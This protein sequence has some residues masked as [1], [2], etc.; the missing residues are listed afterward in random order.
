M[1][2]IVIC[3][4]MDKKSNNKTVEFPTEFCLGNI[5]NKYGYADAEKVSFKVNVYH[6]LFDY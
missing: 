4:L 5:S 6:F 2:V 1:V 3:F